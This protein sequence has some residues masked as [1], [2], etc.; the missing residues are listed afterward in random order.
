MSIIILGLSAFFLGCHD[1]GFS[2]RRPTGNLTEEIAGMKIPVLWKTAAYAGGSGYILRGGK[3]VFQWGD[4]NKLYEL[5]STTKSIGITALGLAVRDGLVSLHDHVNQHCK[6]FGVM[7][8]KNRDTGWL[9]DITFLHLATHTAGFDKPGGYV[10]LLYEPGTVWAYS[11]SGPNWLADC[12]TLLYGRDLKL[13]LFERVFQRLGVTP[14]DLTWRKNMYREKNIEGITRREFGSGISANVSAMAQI[15][16]LYLQGGAWN[17]EQ[18][19]PRSFVE[20][21]RKPVPAIATLP[22]K[23]DSHAQYAG[24]SGHYG[25]L[26]WNNADGALANVPQDAFW[27]WGL[28]DSIIAVIPSLDIV[29]SRAGESWKGKRSPSY[30]RILEPFLEPI[31]ESVNYGAPYP[32]SPV[33][34][35]IVWDDKS[36]IKRKAKGSDNWP[37]T[38]ADDDRLYTAYGDGWGFDPKVPKKLSLGFARVEGTPS[39][40]SGIN[41]RSADEQNGDGRSGKKAS[42]MLMVDGTLYMWVRNANRKG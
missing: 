7:P 13:V 31:V 33:V 35:S 20:T 25:L 8:S 18:I 23:N 19:I 2:D 15:G 39:N 9:D 3:P 21:V 40:F 10:P 38:W 24:A 26:W 36:K 4:V 22:V 34:S 5:K 16:L 41:I 37:I 27:S 1:N 14:L 12:L 11:D 28:Y 29:V 17:G 42:G 32:N 30:Y 6:C